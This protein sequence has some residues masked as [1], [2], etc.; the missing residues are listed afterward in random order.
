[1]LFHLSED[2]GI[3]RFDPRPSDYTPEPVV[4]AISEERLCNYL[5]PRDCPR[6]TFYAGLSTSKAD[7]QQFLGESRAVI[8]VES[9]WLERIRSCRLYGYHLPGE[10]FECLDQCAGYFI[11][12]VSVVPDGVEV[13]DDLVGDIVKRDVE[14]RFMPSLRTLRDAVVAST[15]EFSLIRMRNA[16]PHEAS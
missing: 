11:S 10:N 14:L 2:K 8:A 7:I 9:S 5:L 6:V 15:L 12:R 3:E 1:M 4:W 16:L 13:F